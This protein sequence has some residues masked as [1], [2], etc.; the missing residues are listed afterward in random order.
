MMRAFIVVLALALLAPFATA[1][2]QTDDRR[3]PLVSAPPRTAVYIVFYWRAKP[4]QLDAYNEYIRTVAEPIDE[5]AR[6]AGAFEEVHTVLPAPGTTTEWTHLRMFRLK[7]AA[8]AEALQPALD[9]AKLRVVPDEARKA[10]DAR[11]ATL[12]DLVRREV[13]T[14]LP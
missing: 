4:R 12:R 10:N 5:E 1:F 6:R 3:A 13:W 8:A 7:N 14:E 2:G 11:A 9:A